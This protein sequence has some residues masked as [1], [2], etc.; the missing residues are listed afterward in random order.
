MWVLGTEPR[1][2]GIVVSALNHLA[3]SLVLY[4]TILNDRM[5]G[6]LKVLIY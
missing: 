2:F 5:K 4:I 1:P 3:I 6:F